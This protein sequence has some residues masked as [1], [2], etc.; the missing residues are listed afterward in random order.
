ME[1]VVTIRKDVP[2]V[3]TAYA[4]Y[5]KVKLALADRPG[6]KLTG[7]ISNHFVDEEIPEQ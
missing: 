7:H 2:D 4:L 1:M 5:E 3:E 6:V